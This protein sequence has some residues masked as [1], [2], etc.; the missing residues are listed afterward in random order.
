MKNLIIILISIFIFLGCSDKVDTG[1]KE[2]N[3]DRASCE[4]CA[5]MLGDEDFATQA[6][7]L[8][9]GKEYNFD[10]IGCAIKWM[11]QAG[12]KIK[13]NEVN[14]FVR[15]AENDKFINAKEAK[16][17][18]NRV[19]PMSFNFLAHPRDTKLEKYLT[20]DEIVVKVNNNSSSNHNHNR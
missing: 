19:S 8:E 7:S 6:V 12:N 9:D 11:S 2:I 3:W 13:L 15:N 5:M 14:L 18:T 4:R 10:D 17:T 20:F 1:V 16:Y